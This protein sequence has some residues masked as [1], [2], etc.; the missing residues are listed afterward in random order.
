[1]VGHLSLKRARALVSSGSGP[2][3]T[4]PSAAASALAPAGCGSSGHLD[5]LSINVLHRVAR[6]DHVSDLQRTVAA[7]M[8]AKW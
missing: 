7:A 6:G 3:V 1:M 2:L 8:E 4:G 5:A